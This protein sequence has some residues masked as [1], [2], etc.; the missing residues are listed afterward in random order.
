MRVTCES[1]RRVTQEWTLLGMIQ[2]T[3]HIMGPHWDGLVLGSECVA[4]NLPLEQMVQV[5]ALLSD[6][7]LE[8]AVERVHEALLSLMMIPVAMLPANRPDLYNPHPGRDREPW[9]GQEED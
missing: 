9:Q 1:V 4:G 7:Q 8:D 6:E 3:V 2:A 5:V